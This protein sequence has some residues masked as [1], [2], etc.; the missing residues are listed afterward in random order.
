MGW[1]LPGADSV[2]T[3][4]FCA[5][6]PAGGVVVASGGSFSVNAA[7]SNTVDAGTV[8]GSRG[9][10][11]D[12]TMSFV[13]NGVTTLSDEEIVAAV[14]QVENTLDGPS[15]SLQSVLSDKET[16][17]TILTFKVDCAT[18]ANFQTA[19]AYQTKYLGGYPVDLSKTDIAPVALVSD[20]KEVSSVLAVAMVA[21]LSFAF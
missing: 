11:Q 9:D 16:N 15:V 19:T 8:L 2:V 12:V 3:G 13:L 14:Q 17:Q 18:Y 5:F 6:K 4:G 7:R 20:Q 21:V 10:V 1:C